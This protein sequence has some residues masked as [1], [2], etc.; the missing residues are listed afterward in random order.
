MANLGYLVTFSA[1]F[2]KVRIREYVQVKS[3]GLS[4]HDLG[5][6]NWLVFDTVLY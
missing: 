5:K 3:K 6:P 2:V 4:E 1:M